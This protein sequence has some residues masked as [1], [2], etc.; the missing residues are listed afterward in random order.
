M[1]GKSYLVGGVGLCLMA[2]GSF[3][4]AAECPRG[5]TLIAGA[6]DYRPYQKVEGKEVT[7]MDFEVLEAVLGKL[8][9]SLEVQ[10]LPWARHLKGVQDGTV[11]I[12]SPVSKNEEREAFATFSSPYVDA[13]EVLFVAQGKEN[14]FDNLADFFENGG[15]LGT[16]REYAYGGDFAS[17]KE[18]YGGQI[19]ETD[20]LESNLKKLAAGRVDAT[21]GEVFV[22]SEEI[23]RLGLSDKVV[24]SQTVI[25]S[26]PSYY[27]FSKASVPADFVAAFSTEMQNMKDSGEFD[28]ITG[29]YR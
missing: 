25:S 17:L 1:F 8:G 4:Q 29:K 14:G 20:S 24:A 26:D 5:G 10:A 11:D 6:S 9:C 2:G 7:G 28:G 19:E 15:K 3:A 13:Q 18:Q 22:V 16:I 21:L 23:K 27:M 12:A